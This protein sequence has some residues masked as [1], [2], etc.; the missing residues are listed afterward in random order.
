M[1][2]DNIIIK[3]LLIDDE[4]GFYDS[5]KNKAAAKNINL[6]YKKSLQEGLEALRVDKSIRGVILD[7]RGF[8]EANQTKGSEST[9]FVYTAIKEISLLEQKQNQYYA[10]VVLT[11]W[12]DQLKEGLFGQVELFDKKTISYNPDE[13]DRLFSQLRKSVEGSEDLKI[14]NTFKDVFQVIGDPYL[15]ESQEIKLVHIL[16]GLDTSKG[17]FNYNEV[18]IFLETIWKR[19][20]DK[21][22]QLLPDNLFLNDGR[23]N[24]QYILDFLKGREVFRWID[25][26]TRKKK[27]F[28]Q[29]LLTERIPAHIND[30]M[31]F[32]KEI[33]SA[34]S[35]D[36]KPHYNHYS[37]QAC[38]YAL[39]EIILWL[40]EYIDKNRIQD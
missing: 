7:G 26:E 28:H 20:N 21:D 3:I 30:C 16:K 32:V 14:L 13:L 17:E 6:V 15:D 2:S 35:H 9:N 38:V 10:K 19:L 18:R 24:L 36:Y 8:I 1:N 33:C 23:P 39:L 22:L 25:Y 40:K 27:V 37:Y 31:E 5:L 34:I 12:M 4:N 11:A 29:R